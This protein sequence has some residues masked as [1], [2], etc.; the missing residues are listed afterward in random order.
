MPSDPNQPA[1]QPPEKATVLDLK[2]PPPWAI[3]LTKKVSDGFRATEDHFDK[4]DETLAR[5]ANESVSAASRLGRVESTI[6]DYG[7]R[8]VVIEGRQD[9]TSM[10]VRG[11]S[12]S[13]DGQNMQIA[14][15]SVKV[16]ELA[17]KAVE[18]HA[19]LATITGL[20]D[21]PLVKKIGYAFGA[22]L[23]AALTAGT[24]YLARG[25]VQPTPPTIIQVQK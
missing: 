3:E 16:D 18:T 6:A 24:G 9:K 14:S 1:V 20:L 15:L 23:L 7:S 22:L 4:Q 19:M 17:G 25:N 5:L 10:S 12:Q 8:I 21:K 13:D 11:V 2:A